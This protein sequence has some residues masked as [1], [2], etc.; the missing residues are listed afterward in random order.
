M[1]TVKDN[2][3]NFTNNDY[4]WAIRAQELQVTVR[5]LSDKAFIKILKASSLPNCPVTRQDVIIANKLFGPDIGT[6]KCKTTR[7]SPPIVYSPIS[8]DITPILKYYGEVTLCVDVMYVSKVPL[9]VTLCQNIKFGMVEAVA[10]RKEATLLK[11]IGAVVTLYGKARFK[12]TTVL[13]DGEFVPLRG[14]FT[15]L[16]ITLNETSRDYV[17]FPENSS[18]AGDQNDQNSSVLAKHIP[19]DGGT[20]QDLNRILSKAQNPYGLVLM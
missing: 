16:G 13:M 20:S 3:K 11:C 17:A 4:L 14:G 5:C 2:K 1:N 8:V 19:S 10:D 9:L 7:R 18:T 6:L 12:I 15:E